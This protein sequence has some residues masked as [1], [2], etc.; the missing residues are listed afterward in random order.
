MT[1]PRQGGASS[2]RPAQGTSVR[3]IEVQA[4]Q[5]PAQ[6]AFRFARQWA[7][8]EETEARRSFTAG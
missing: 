1:A 3:W 2:G 8:V 5:P 7:H 4:S 6:G